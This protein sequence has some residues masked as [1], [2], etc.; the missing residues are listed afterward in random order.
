MHNVMKYLSQIDRFSCLYFKEKGINK[1]ITTALGS[2]KQARYCEILYYLLLI[3][4][5]LEKVILGSFSGVAVF[6]YDKKWF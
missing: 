5:A 1:E 3:C 2:C 6:F 4:F